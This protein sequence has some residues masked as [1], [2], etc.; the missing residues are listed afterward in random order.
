[1]RDLAFASLAQDRLVS[2][3]RVGNHAS[4]RVAEKI[5]MSLVE[6]TERNGVLYWLYRVE[7]TS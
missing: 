3:I 6:K 7:A 1:M 5:G 2:L 4:R